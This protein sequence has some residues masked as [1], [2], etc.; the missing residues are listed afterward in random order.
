MTD[1]LIL[2]PVNAQ[3]SLQLHGEAYIRRQGT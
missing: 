3:C 1:Y 2:F